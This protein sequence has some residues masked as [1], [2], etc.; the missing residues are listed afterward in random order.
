MDLTFYNYL[1]S[2]IWSCLFLVIFCLLRRMYNFIRVNGYFPLFLLLFLAFIRFF[3]TFELP[4]TWALETNGLFAAVPLGLR[5]EV[6][7]LSLSYKDLLVLIWV[8]VSIIL[9]MR[10]ALWILWQRQ[11][12]ARLRRV[13][14]VNVRSALDSLYAERPKLPRGNVVVS[15]EVECPCVTGFFT[16]TILLPEINLPQEDWK[17]ILLHELSHFSNGDMWLKLLIDAIKAVFWWNPLAYLIEKDLDYVLEIRSDA[18]ATGGYSEEEKIA[19]VRAVTD[20]IRV[21]LPAA[22]KQTYTLA[23]S[24]KNSR[25]K[26]LDRMKLV[27]DRPK[28]WRKPIEFY[29]LIFLLFIVSYSFVVQPYGKPPKEE[30][31]SAATIEDVYIFEQDNCY[32]VCIDGELKTEVSPNELTEEPYK[33]FEIRKGE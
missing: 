10:D 9:L 22:P 23:V 3:V 8:A 31:E 32:Y 30:V 26:L 13:D 17:Y 6:G 12:I 24:G 21:I 16:F 15:P 14:C 19:Y 25:D 20:V 29:T 7:M 28:Q 11:R 18:V 27:L 1:A 4:F 33:Y 5:K 2:F